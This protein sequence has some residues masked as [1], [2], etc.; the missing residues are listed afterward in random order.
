MSTDVSIFCI[1][2][3]MK[4]MQALPWKQ[5]TLAAQ[6]LHDSHTLALRLQ[7]TLTFQLSAAL[8]VALG[9]FLDPEYSI[10]CILLLCMYTEC[11]AR[12]LHI[13]VKVARQV[14]LAQFGQS[15]MTYID[16]ILAVSL[17]PAYLKLLFRTCSLCLPSVL[18]SIST[19]FVNNNYAQNAI[20]AYVY[21]YAQG[22]QA[23]L[24]QVDWDQLPLYLC[25]FSVVLARYSEYIYKERGW[26]RSDVLRY[27]FQ[28]MR[29]L[30]FDVLIRSLWTATAGAPKLLRTSVSLSLVLAIDALGFVHWTVLQ[31]V[32]GYAILQTAQQINA[33]E[34]VALDTVSA[35]A[36]AIMLLSARSACS[37][38]PFGVYFPEL[39]QVGHTIGDVFCVASLS[40]L[41][42]SMSSIDEST[43]PEE[44]FLWISCVCIV[45]YKVQ[46]FLLLAS[47]IVSDQL[48]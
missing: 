30:L 21:Q 44:H 43:S 38:S 2:M 48:L 19:T 46:A 34:I 20:S 31:D 39:L 3:V 5:S 45:A 23:V 17:A 7:S 16:K 29:I 36:V 32:R 10:A 40:A 33:L 14:L 41:L 42:Q 9:T 13:Q 37:L 1:L 6:V 24:L 22:S 26:H 12:V 47:N 27:V 25:A 35:V 28:G 11:L 8:Q 15:L 4:G 18:S